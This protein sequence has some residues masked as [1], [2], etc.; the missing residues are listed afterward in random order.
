MSRSTKL[1][2]ATSD[3]GQLGLD[4][5]ELGV[6]RRALR[7]LKRHDRAAALAIL[8]EAY[9]EAL[10]RYCYN[11]VRCAT[12]ADDVH[13]SVFV[14]AFQDIETFSGTSFRPWLYAIAHHRCLDALKVSRR[15]LKRFIFC[16]SM[17]EELDPGPNSEE[18]LVRSSLASEIEACLGKLSPHVRIAV[19][20]RYQ[21][22]FTY[23][24]MAQVCRERPATL[25]ARVARAMPALRRCLEAK[26]VRL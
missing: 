19:L 3:T 20:L 1:G 6:D 24:Q 9:G 23:E 25:Q 4:S 2:N 22:G 11:V 5:A 8:M 7:A 17:P 13:Q 14:Q 15:W 10:Y 16:D 12:M 18:R 21:E 26:G